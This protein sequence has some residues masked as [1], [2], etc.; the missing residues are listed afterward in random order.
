MFAL[1]FAGC[2]GG[3][4]SPSS[5]AGNGRVLAVYSGS[6]QVGY[7][8]VN[9]QHVNDTM[10]TSASFT[11]SAS[12]SDWSFTL[13]ANQPPKPHMPLTT[14]S[15]V[16]LNA[17]Q[18]MDFGVYSSRSDPKQIIYVGSATFMLTG[19]FTLYPTANG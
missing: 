4:D 8:T 17:G 9:Q 13:T 12:I 15:P 18:S 2:G 7:F 14:G 10:E 16:A 11:A 6:T 3:S 19:K 5:S 1:L